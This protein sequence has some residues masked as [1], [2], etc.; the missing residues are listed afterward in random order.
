MELMNLMA[1]L[2]LNTDEYEKALGEAE[3]Q[4]EKLD[5]PEQKIKVDTGG[6]S[7]SLKEA[8]T[9]ADTF[10]ESLNAVWDGIKISLI[11]SGISA[12]ITGIFNTLSD[13]VNLAAKLGDD[14]DKGAKRLNISTDAY[15][16][17][18]HAL[19]QSGASISDF[20]R[21]ILNINKLL[22]GGEVSKT[23]A[24]AFD[25]LGISTKNANGSLKTTEEYL[26]DTV[27]ALADFKGTNEERGSI[28][29]AI[30][31]KGGNDLNALFAEGADGIQALIKEAHELGLVMSK[32]DVAN[33]VKY[34]DSV[35]NVQSSMEAF[36]TS[37]ATGI[38]PV[39]TDVFNQASKIIAFFNWR[40]GD[41]P[42]NE[43][44]K[45]ID[46]GSMD[47][48]A[49][50][51]M[52]ES[53]AGNLADKLIAMGDASKLTAEQQAI[54]KGTAEELIGLIPSLSGI[55]DTDTGSI[56]GNSAEI[57]ENIK[58]WAA[59]SRER[60]LAQAK[61]EKQRALMNKNKDA[62]D[63]QVQMNVKAA[64]AEAARGKAIEEVNKVLEA[65]GMTDRLLGE[66]ATAADIAQLRKDIG[67]NRNNTDLQ[68]ELAAAEDI[69]G[70]PLREL[71]D[72]QRQFES[73]QAQLEAGQAEYE[74]W[75]AAA[76][77]LF[78]GAAESAGEAEDAVDKVNEALKELPN[79]KAITLD[80]QTNWPRLLGMNLNPPKLAKGAWNIPYDDF[81]ALL[82]KNEM[83]L[84]A[85]QARDYR[86]GK[87]GGS[88]P[89]ALIETLQAL[90]NDFQNMQLVVG[91][92][93]FGN[94]VV[95]YGG[96]KVSGYIGRS[97]SRY[98]AGYGT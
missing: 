30:F 84:N 5:I 98:Y 39:L 71:E 65:H 77:A 95:D 1:K 6:F 60:A 11:G 85:S 12:A 24:E 82:H 23:V 90:R 94:A 64:E 68:K 20:Q 70:K 38:L 59:L 66:G 36:K 50:I 67:F 10:G 47:A 45:S 57:K 19:S 72:L 13:C 80:V 33:A 93:V 35:A 74:A 63:A 44:F 76:D 42:L 37:L 86:E 32:E 3:K 53:V 49:S 91:E 55:I 14:V 88:D 78:G 8:E 97:E 4:A 40:T 28:V 34:G 58:Q 26:A 73:Y 16:E 31:G 92:K 41:T 54:W 2:T 75:A 15:Q 81:P 62:I 46:E 61:E 17:W 79:K 29:E 56:K 69:V 83:V 21:G 52:T 43:Q 22:G 89:L 9:D 25:K 7:E 51:N 18:S 27:K 87:R 48:L 96:H